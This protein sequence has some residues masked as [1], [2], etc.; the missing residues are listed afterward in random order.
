MPLKPN[1]DNFQ[2]VPI[3]PSGPTM[4]SFMFVS[5][6]LRT[7]LKP[8]EFIKEWFFF[9]IFF[10]SQ[11]DFRRH[12]STYDVQKHPVLCTGELLGVEGDL[13]TH[14]CCC[15]RAASSLN[16]HWP[17]AWSQ[18]LCQR[19]VL[20]E[21]WGAARTQ[22]ARWAGWW[23]LPCCPLPLNKPWSTASQRPREKMLWKLPLHLSYMFSVK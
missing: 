13:R 1:S 8:V 19:W 16:P 11:W 15:I 21:V 6:I 20:A 5:F 12:G 3:L 18:W 4:R 14:E 7:N 22:S 23:W 10:I 2:S 9:P 17:A